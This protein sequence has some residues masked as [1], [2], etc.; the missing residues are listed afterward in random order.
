MKAHLNEQYIRITLKS[1]ADTAAAAIVQRMMM[2][3]RP[4]VLLLVLP[5]SNGSIG[6]SVGMV[7]PVDETTRRRKKV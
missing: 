5:R 3:R 6:V 7:A 2:R 1:L 4:L